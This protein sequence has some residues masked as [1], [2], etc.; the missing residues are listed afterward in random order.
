M[1]PRSHIIEAVHAACGIG[2]HALVEARLSEIGP[3]RDRAAPAGAPALPPRFLRHADEQ[4]VV[5]V[6]A[7]LE[8]LAAHP[9][10]PPSFTDYGVVAAPCRAGRFATAQ[11]LAQARVG[12][13]V[14]VSPHVVPQ[15][16]LHSLAGA[17]SVAFGL[18]GPNVGTS[19]GDQAVAEGLFTAL[20]LLSTDV[21]G[22][23]LVLCGWDH[24]PHLDDQGRPTAAAVPEPLCRSLAIALTADVATGAGLQF[25]VRPPESDVVGPA[26]DSG[27]S[28]A[29]DILSLAKALDV[30]RTASWSHRCPWPAEFVLEPVRKQAHGPRA[31]TARTVQEA[32]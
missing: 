17:V 18:H 2:S 31:D 24:E 13:G 3:L 22:I 29:A 14:A 25:A 9:A 7:V 1:S 16:S 4:T 20:S 12:G 32:A 28:V 5:G 21:A 11:S 23:W 19:G 26:A 15:C 27:P 10:A 8:A 6:R 30:G